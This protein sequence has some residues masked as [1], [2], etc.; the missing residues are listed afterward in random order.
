MILIAGKTATGKDTIVKELLSRGYQK[1]VTYTTRDKRIGEIEGNTYHF[2]SE[3][4]FAKKWR[5]GFFVQTTSYN[6]VNGVKFYGSNIEDYDKDKIM[7]VNPKGVAAIKALKDFNP[8]VFYIVTDEEI[9]KERLINRG[10]DP[11]EA[12]RRLEADNN[13]FAGFEKQFDYAIRNDGNLTPSQI[14][15][16][17]LYLY[18]KGGHI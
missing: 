15:D 1:V 2:I 10:D 13:D 7:I 8:I 18:Q 12:Q 14:A 9:I 4:D 5:E 11:K 6:T 3:E 17:I 16:M